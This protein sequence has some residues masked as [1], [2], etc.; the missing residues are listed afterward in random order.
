MIPAIFALSR[1][2]VAA[3]DIGDWA[4]FIIIIAALIAVVIV[5]LR[6]FGYTIPQWVWAI[7]AICIAA[8]IGVAAVRFLMGL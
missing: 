4:I 1:G 8:L 6:V 3:W 2:G 7:I 5:V